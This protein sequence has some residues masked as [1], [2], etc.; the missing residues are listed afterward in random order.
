MVAPGGPPCQRCGY[1]LRW[2][3]EWNAWGCDRCRV[4][5]PATQQPVPFAQAMPPMQP[6]AA[7]AQPPMPHAPGAHAPKSKQWI[8]FALGGLVLA[9]GAV[10]IIVLATGGKK[11]GM[12]SANEVFQAALD[13][14]ARGDIDGL[15]ALAGGDGG[16]TDQIEC[17]DAK[18]K[19]EMNDEMV[20][21][22]RAE[23]TD[24]AKAWKD[25]A[26]TAGVASPDGDPD[27]MKAGKEEDGCSA[28][29]DLSS[30]RYKVKVK[31]KDAEDDLRFTVVQIGDRYFLESLPDTP[32]SNE[33]AQLGKMRD[34]MCACKDAACASKVNDDFKPFMSSMQ[35]KFKDGKATPSEDEMKVGEEMA[36]CMS[37]A[38]GTGSDPPPPPPEPSA[39]AIDRSSPD[40]IAAQAAKAAAAG[41]ADALFALTGGAD[42]EGRVFECPDG[43]D[44]AISGL[45]EDQQHTADSWKG[46]HASVSGMVPA[47]HETVHAGD[48]LG[49][50]K[51]KTDLEVDA[52]DMTIA[53]MSSDGEVHGMKGTIVVA[54]LGGQWYLVDYPH[55]HK[56]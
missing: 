32:P 1:P 38:I 31:T 11:G 21:H 18:K 48:P 56:P 16:L 43:L 19:S 8:F 33:K 47:Q 9:A 22:L 29:V 20:K 15:V 50:C 28:K 39:A 24:D 10:V 42:F 12:K 46:T 44:T 53:F 7:Y 25:L 36:E 2:V 52:C 6:Q 45:K 40:A 51:L 30:Q 23:L 34:A 26:A 54:Q 5:F 49:S 35:D 55:E 37:K 14:A 41:D 3:P 17:K 13:R 4:T 27:V